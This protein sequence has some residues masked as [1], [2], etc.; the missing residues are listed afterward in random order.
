[1]RPL[2]HQEATAWSAG[3]LILGDS[4]GGSNRGVSVH[5][6]ESRIT[7]ELRNLIHNVPIAVLKIYLP[8]PERHVHRPRAR[9]LPDRL[10]MYRIGEH[11][12]TVG[13]EPEVVVP[14][15]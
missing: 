3:N 7:R 2:P 13:H 8:V 11:Q 6:S 9:C 4:N 15:H 12:G 14:G 5:H 10:T 1:M